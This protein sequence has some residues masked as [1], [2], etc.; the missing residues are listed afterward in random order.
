MA[1]SGQSTSGR[2]WKASATARCATSI[3]ST[4]SRSIAR[5]TRSSGR[6]A[7]TLIRPPFTTGPI[8]RQAWSRSRGAGRPPATARRPANRRSERPAL[9]AL[10]ELHV[11]EALAP[12]GGAEPKV[13]LAD[14]V[15]AAQL[16]GRTVEDDPAVLHDVAVIR[17]AQGHLGVLLDE[18]ERRPPLL[19]D[20][21]DDVEDLAH[22]QRREPE[23]RLVQQQE[24]GQGH[25][26]AADDEHLLL[27]STQVARDL[28]AARHED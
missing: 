13:E 18:Q 3:S 4:P 10:V 26:G 14:V 7:P 9:A 19:V 27:A 23:R 8:M 16:G 28:V 17:D 12:A 5:F 15:V 24:L 6:T 22:E 21:A 2:F 1:R 20:L 25:E 11:R